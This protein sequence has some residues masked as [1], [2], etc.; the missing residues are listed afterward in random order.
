MSIKQSIICD[1]C[2]EVLAIQDDHTVVGITVTQ[3]LAIQHRKWLTEAKA[4][5][6]ASVRGFLLDHHYC[7]EACFRLAIMKLSTSLATKV[8]EVKS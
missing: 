7:C 2:G 3:P 1:S 5:T 4:G 6:T 8:P